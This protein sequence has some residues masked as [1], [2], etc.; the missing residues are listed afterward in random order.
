MTD[1][2][3]HRSPKTTKSFKGVY[4]ARLCRS[5]GDDESILVTERMIWIKS[6]KVFIRHSEAQV[7]L[8]LRQPTYR[9]ND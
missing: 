8:S 2:F 6:Q 9:L 1:Y 7:W 3:I 5:G 4:P